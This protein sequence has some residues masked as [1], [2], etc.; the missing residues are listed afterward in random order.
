MY[1]NNGRP[2]VCCLKNEKET[3]AMG[4]FLTGVEWG[5]LG[6]TGRGAAAGGVTG[7]RGRVREE[8]AAQ[9]LPPS[10]ARACRGSAQ[11]PR[12][13]PRAPG[14][15]Q[16]QGPRSQRPQSP[17]AAL[18]SCRPQPVRQQEVTFSTVCPGSLSPVFEPRCGF[19]YGLS[20]KDDCHHL[21]CRSPFK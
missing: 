2:N 19:L 11:S 3:T 17:P 18:E 12:A 10:P 6:S 4:G 21:W 5:Q 13:W 15:A 20:K 14:S 8:A 7:E 16:L 1:I 9:C